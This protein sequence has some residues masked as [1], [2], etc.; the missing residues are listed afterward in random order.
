[1]QNNVDYCS[2]YLFC[3]AENLMYNKKNSCKTLEISVEVF[4]CWNNVLPLPNEKSGMSG[5]LPPVSD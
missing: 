4:P 3:A 2:L 1:M 5:I